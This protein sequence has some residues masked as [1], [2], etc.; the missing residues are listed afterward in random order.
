MSTTATTTIKLG[1]LSRA[2]STVPI[3]NK[4]VTQLPLRSDEN[5]VE[6]AATGAKQ[7]EISKRRSAAII[8]T[9]AGVNLLNVTGSGILTVAL[10]QMGRD[11]SLPRELLLW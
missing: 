8:V 10:P 6:T 2:G 7:N 11:L 1:E 9:V 3:S 4:E 5:V